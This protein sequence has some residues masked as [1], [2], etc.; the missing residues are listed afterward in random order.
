MDTYVVTLWRISGINLL[1]AGETIRECES[2]QHFRRHCL[3][4]LVSVYLEQ[5]GA[6]GF[7][8]PKGLR[9]Y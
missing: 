6:L 7:C 3:R 4:Y 9:Q 1:Q 5:S 2:L 8:D